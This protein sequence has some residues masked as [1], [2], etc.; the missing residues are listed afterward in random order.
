M[1]ARITQRSQINVGIARGFKLLVVWLFIYHSIVGLRVIYWVCSKF[2][3]RVKV[4][5]GKC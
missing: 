3:K 1:M 5:I 2:G 4:Q